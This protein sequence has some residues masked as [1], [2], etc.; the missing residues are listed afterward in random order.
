MAVTT[1]QIRTETRSRLARLKAHRRES[2]DD[3]VNRLLSLVPEGDDEGRYTSEFRIGLM[4]ARED[5]RAGRTIPHAEV[6]R[7][8]GL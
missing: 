4:E 7:R 3:L 2:F 5:V 8:L 1:I 6:K